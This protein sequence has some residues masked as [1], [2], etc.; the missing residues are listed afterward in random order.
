MSTTDKVFAGSV[1]QIYQQLMVPLIFAPYARD[2]A[3]RIAR[4][5]PRNLLETACGTGVVNGQ[6]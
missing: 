6:P 3:A 5:R 4:A 2:L 1:P